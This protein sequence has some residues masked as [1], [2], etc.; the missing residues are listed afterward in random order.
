MDQRNWTAAA[1]IIS[2]RVIDAPRERVFRAFSDPDQLAQWWGPAGSTNTFQEFDFRPG[3]AWRFVM[4]GPDGADYQMDHQF[5]EISQPARIVFVHL[6]EGHD[7]RMTM[8]FVDE[9]GGTRLT[10]E[11]QFASP[12]EAERVREFVTV[13]NGQNLDRLAS[14]LAAMP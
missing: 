10:W 6:Q 14:Q 9:A 5:V 2:V 8:T 7:F 1:P 4:H 3:G 13:A 11:M 12:E